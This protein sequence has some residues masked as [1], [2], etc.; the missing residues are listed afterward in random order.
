MIPP[1]GFDVGLECRSERS[2]I[3]ETG[4]TTIDLEGLSEEEL[5]L[6]QILALLALVLLGQINWLSTL[7][8]LGTTLTRTWELPW[9]WLPRWRC[10][11][12]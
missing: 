8:I 4:T 6:Q 5:S 10:L 1:L 2:K 3:I 9:N 7:L 11:S 12:S